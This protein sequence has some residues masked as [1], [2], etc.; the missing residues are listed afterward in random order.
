MKSI[1]NL[2]TIVLLVFSFIACSDSESL[3][4]Y[5]VDNSENS[6]FIS[7]TIPSSVLN[8]SDIEITPTQKEAYE[9][10]KKLNVLAFKVNED[11]KSDFEIEKGKV[12]TILKNKKYQELMRINSG[13]HQGVVKYLGDDRSI[14]EVIVYGNDNDKGFALVRVLGENMKPEGMLQL[15]QVV[16]SNNIKGEG[17]NQLKQFFEK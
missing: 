9:S 10:V 1:K 6:N 16:K 2:I 3:Q 12:T 5:Y 14:D 7:L 8:L 13:N 15:M 4:Q 11:N 17:L